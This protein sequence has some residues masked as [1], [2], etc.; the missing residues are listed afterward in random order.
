MK[1]PKQEQ[2]ETTA[3]GY[4]IPQQHGTGALLPVRLPGFRSTIPLT[5]FSPGSVSPTRT[6]TSTI[7]DEALGPIVLCVGP[8]L[9]F[10][11][12]YYPKGYHFIEREL[13]RAGVEFRKDDKCFLWVA[14]AQA[15]QAA[16]TVSAPSPFGNNSTTGLLWWEPKFSQQGRAA[17]NLRRHYCL[18]SQL[19][20]P[21]ELPHR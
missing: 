7:R 20:L 18:Q 19:R 16:A 14:D 8:F 5:A 3:G 13:K 21:T 12:T 6:I 17:L 15:L 10:S 9:P 4:F 2:P 1:L 11:I